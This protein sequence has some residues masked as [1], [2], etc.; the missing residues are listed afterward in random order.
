MKY[1]FIIRSRRQ[2]LYMLYLTFLLHVIEAPVQA[3]L[4]F[5]AP[6]S[7]SVSQLLYYTGIMIP[8]VASQVLL[9][10]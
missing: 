9:T 7:Q 8:A 5:C 10:L 6:V 2:S 4:L 1:D 3:A